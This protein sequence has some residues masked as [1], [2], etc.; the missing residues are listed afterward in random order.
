MRSRS[1]LLCSLLSLTLAYT[2]APARAATDGDLCSGLAML[3][4]LPV[5][6]VAGIASVFEAKSPSERLDSAVSGYNL[7]GAKQIV[8]AA[9]PDQRGTLL[10]GMVR[11][12]I[13]AYDDAN[14][15]RLALITSML[16]ERR[17]DVSG[18]LGKTMLQAVV[19][20]R[21]VG[22][23]QSQAE[24]ER[25][26][27]LAK[28]FIA[29]GARADGVLLGD[30]FEC[31][32]EV[33]FVRAMS[34]A[35]ADINR[36]SDRSPLFD[37]NAEYGDLKAAERLIAA[38]ADPNGRPAGGKGML[39]RMAAQCD[40]KPRSPARSPA[41]DAYLQQCVEESVRRTRFAVT[42]GA[43]PNGRTTWEQGK[44]ETPYAVALKTQNTALA[45]A[46]RELGAD[47][48]FSARCLATA[49]RQP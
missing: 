49:P 28:L 22:S 21:L 16:D 2:P 25:Q 45:D 1:R 44:C 38:G 39:Q 46:L 6:L 41:A 7:D 37:R 34:H 43:D 13:Q 29:H 8:L 30:C 33:E 48:E 19:S 23:Q 9:G 47:P 5:A 27:T 14:P 32:T 3:I 4:C 17:I 42:H 40:L 20:G 11:R 15:V 18:D 36:G 26:L 12:Y 35:G 24:L 10:A 31:N